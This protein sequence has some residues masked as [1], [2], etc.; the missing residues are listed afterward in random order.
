MVYN[1]QLFSYMYVF[2]FI[3]ATSLECWG[4]FWW[5]VD[6]IRNI[7]NSFVDTITFVSL[8]LIFILKQN[9]FFKNIQNF[10]FMH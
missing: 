8:V 10:S 6:E 7:V 3:E 5:L 1:I 9:M 4:G 2:C